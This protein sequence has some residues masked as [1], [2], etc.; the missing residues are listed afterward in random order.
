MKPYPFASLNHLTVP[1]AMKKHLP[2]YDHERVRKALSQTGLALSCTRRV[3]GVRPD[4]DCGVATRVFAPRRPAF[5]GDGVD[6]P[7]WSL[8]DDLDGLREQLATR[9]T[10]RSEHDAASG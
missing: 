7:P 9:P 4:R 3:A 10:R 8:V 1:L 2:Y 5:S 6:S